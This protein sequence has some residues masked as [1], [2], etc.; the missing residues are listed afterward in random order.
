[1]LSLIELNRFP[2]SIF[3]DTVLCAF[4][5]KA[6]DDKAWSKLNN[7]IDKVSMHVCGHD[8]FTEYKLLVE[9]NKY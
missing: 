1:M 4:S 5:A 2:K 6:V 9:I 8:S 3:A 7:I